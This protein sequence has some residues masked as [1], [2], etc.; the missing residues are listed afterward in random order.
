MSA[1]GSGYISLKK[2]LRYRMI[3]DVG[4][5]DWIKGDTQWMDVIS[6]DLR[7][8]FHKVKCAS[9]RVHGGEERGLHRGCVWLH[10]GW[11]A[12][13]GREPNSSWPEQTDGNLAWWAE[14]R[15]GPI[16]RQAR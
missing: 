16:R 13:V 6:G 10:V 2:E 8:G 7:N 14:T 11:Q 5:R 9:A 15:H 1:A 3:K 4:L 12:S